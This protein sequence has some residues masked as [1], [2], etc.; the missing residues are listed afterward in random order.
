MRSRELLTTAIAALALA[1][2]VAQAH[3]LSADDPS[4]SPPARYTPAA[5]NALNARNQ[6]M[7]KAY[8]PAEPGGH[9]APAHRGFDWG[10]TALGAAAMLMIVAAFVGSVRLT[11]LT[12]R[13]QDSL[14]TS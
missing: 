3:A 14:R 1:A 6:A 4:P 13:A 8:A 12:R 5:L 7:E 2:P 11:G 10:Y 9:V